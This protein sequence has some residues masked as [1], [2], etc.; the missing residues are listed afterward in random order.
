MNFTK[1]LHRLQKMHKLIKTGHTGTPVEFAARLGISRRQLY[2]E[3]DSLKL[4][5]AP[6]KY[7]REL[8]S[9]IYAD[10]FEL[11]IKLSIKVLN[12]KEEREIYAGYVKNLL[13]CNFFARNAIIFTM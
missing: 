7:S 11:E 6:V 5:E 1:Q 4:I 12:E 2:N 8:E 10:F 13:P 9:F 3:L